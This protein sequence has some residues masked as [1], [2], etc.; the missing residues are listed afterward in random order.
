MSDAR[1]SSA[2]SA[3]PLHREKWAPPFPEVRSVS[4][5][6]VGRHDLKCHTM[7]SLCVGS[8]YCVKWARPD[9]QRRPGGPPA[10]CCH[11]VRRPGTVKLNRSPA[12]P[13]NWNIFPKCSQALGEQWTKCAAHRPAGLRRFGRS[14]GYWQCSSS[15]EIVSN[16]PPNTKRS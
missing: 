15:N 7:G 11:R 14:S 3:E 6:D 12:P 16:L 10:A 8:N 5:L 13:V 2:H 4:R 1:W 9:G